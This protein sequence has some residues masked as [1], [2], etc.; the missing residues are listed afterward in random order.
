MKY[1]NYRSKFIANAETVR[2]MG[3]KMGFV[4]VAC[5]PCWSI[6]QTEEF[7]DSG[8]LLSICDEL[9]GRNDTIPD[10]L[11]AKLA[12]IHNLH[13]KYEATK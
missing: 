13:W 9:C 4:L 3:K 5:D 2:K 12:K 7:S 10:W 1:G 8:L 11:M 6:K